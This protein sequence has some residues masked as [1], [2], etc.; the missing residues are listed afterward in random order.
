MLDYFKTEQDQFNSISLHKY[1]D[2]GPEMT[3]QKKWQESKRLGF[4]RFMRF[5]IAIHLTHAILDFITNTKSGEIIVLELLS[6]ILRGFANNQCN[7]LIVSES[8]Q[9]CTIKSTHV[10]FWSCHML[11]ANQIWEFHSQPQVKNELIN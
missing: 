6:E 1:G 4:M 9:V 3:P 5:L 7:T 11:S 10:R 2:E 8:S